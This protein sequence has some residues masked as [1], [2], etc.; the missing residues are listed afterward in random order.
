MGNKVSR[1]KDLLD[2]KRPGRAEQGHVAPCFRHGK[3]PLLSCIIDNN[4]CCDW[5]MLVKCA[6]IACQQER[7]NCKK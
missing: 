5:Q 4:Y 7:L 1:R 6:L 3:N 2:F